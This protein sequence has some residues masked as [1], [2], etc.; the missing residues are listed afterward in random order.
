MNDKI[1]KTKLNYNLGKDITIKSE[2]LI[3]ENI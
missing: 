3:R 2:A 1:E